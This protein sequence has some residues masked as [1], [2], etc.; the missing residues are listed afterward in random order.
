MNR[1]SRLPANFWTQF[2]SPVGAA[3]GP[4]RMV[5]VVPVHRLTNVGLFEKWWNT[6]KYHVWK[7]YF[8][9]CP[10]P[11]LRGMQCM[12]TYANRFQTHSKY[13]IKMVRCCPFLEVMKIH[14]SQ[15]SWCSTTFLTQGNCPVDALEG[16]GCFHPV[17]RVPLTIVR[18]MVYDVYESW[19][20][21]LW[22]R[23]RGTPMTG[24]KPHFVMKKNE[25]VT[26]F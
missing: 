1:R 26:S 8:P 22:M 11:W 20:I 13:Q 4:R 12:Q 21:H 23:T 3:L 17:K 7:R 16:C 10:W 25:D 6:C 14:K 24:W 9:C 5:G 2:F 15:L 19:K 18:W